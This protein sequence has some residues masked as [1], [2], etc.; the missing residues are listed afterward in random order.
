MY[1]IVFDT[2]DD[3]DKFAQENMDIFASCVVVRVGEK[4]GVDY[5]WNEEFP[6]ECI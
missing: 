6:A 1:R 3:A 5:V 2:F 4:F